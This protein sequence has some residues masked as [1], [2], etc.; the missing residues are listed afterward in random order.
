M[1]KIS[2]DK[3]I[4]RVINQKK[5]ITI[6]T[7]TS[8]LNSSVKTARRRLKLWEA[9]TSYNENGRYYTLPGIPGFDSNGLWDYSQVRFSR[10]GNLKNTVIHLVK[11]SK[12]GLDATQMYELLGI[13]VRSFL[14]SLKNH[15]DL[16]REK[17][18][19][20]FIY[21]SGEEKDYSNQKERRSEITK[22][23]QMPSDI[24]AVTILVETIKNPDLNIDELWLKLQEENCRISLESVQNLF[25]YHGLTIKK[26][27]DLIS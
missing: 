9:I 4:I 25:N 27:P 19:G 10:Y 21:F 16:K 1:T 17:I 6:D 18:Q 5:I 20:R 26:M 12:R 23:M 8:L 14:S 11:E 13:S 3:T 15:P 7:L 2:K 22:K 24:E